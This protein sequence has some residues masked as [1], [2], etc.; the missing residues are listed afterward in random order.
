ARLE[1][2][3]RPMGS[4][5]FAFTFVRRTGEGPVAVM[6]PFGARSVTLILAG[7]L[8]PVGE[9]PPLT[10][11]ELVDGKDLP[12]SPEAI[13]GLALANGRA[14]RIKVLARLRGPEGSIR[15]QLDDEDIIQWSGHIDRLSPM[16]KFLVSSAGGLGVGLA[17]ATVEFRDIELMVLD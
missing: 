2:P 10:G 3:C 4:Y 14:Y 13:R 15:A 9:G 7:Y 12:N 17:N 1:F 5:D 6:L 16:K 8:S 11:L